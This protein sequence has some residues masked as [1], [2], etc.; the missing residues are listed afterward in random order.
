VVFGRN[1]SNQQKQVVAQPPAQ[2]AAR[3]SPLRV[4]YNPEQEAAE[5]RA[6]RELA[7]KHKLGELWRSR[8][9]EDLIGIL[10]DPATPPY[11][12][13]LVNDYC[14]EWHEHDDALDELVEIRSD[15]KKETE[16]LL[17]IK[18]QQQEAVVL[19]N[20]Q[21]RGN[22]IASL[23]KQLRANKIFPQGIELYGEK[24]YRDFGIGKIFAAEESTVIRHRRS[25][26]GATVS[27]TRRKREVE[28]EE[29]PAYE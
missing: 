28:N 19:K 5:Q 21:M 3:E 23:L 6:R 29:P 11:V 17:R 26:A 2:Q 7:V 14:N 22:R 20:L 4:Y 16:P 12:Y 9:D 25:V 1:K 24:E 10:R 13:G 15:I 27:G 8:H 18:Y